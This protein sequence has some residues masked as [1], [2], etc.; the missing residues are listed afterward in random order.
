MANRDVKIAI[1]L[2]KIKSMSK[3]IPKT[4]KVGGK[5]VFKL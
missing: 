4:R 3:F 5:E 2:A 1:K